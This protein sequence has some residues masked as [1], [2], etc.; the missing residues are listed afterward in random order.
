MQEQ[1][2]ALFQ[3]HLRGKLKP[4]GQGNFSTTCP[5]H[6][7]GMEK[8]P[9]FS[10]HPEKGTFHCFTCHT[11]GTVKKLLFLLGL[12]RAQIDAET[13]AVAPFLKRTQENARIQ[14]QHYFENKDPFSANPELPEVVLALYDFTPQKLIDDGFDPTILREMQIG[15]DRTNQRITYP[16]RDVHG[17]LAG[18]AGG[19]VQRGVI[20]KY[21]VYQG[22]Y[23]VNGKKVAGDFGES[24]DEEF[25]GYRF[26]NHQHIWNLDSVY[27]DVIASTDRSITVYLA[28]G[29]KACIWLRMAGLRYVVALMGSYISENQQ[30]LLH[31][32]GCSV[33]LFLDNDDAGRRGTLNVGDLLYKPLRGQVNVVPYPMHDVVASMQNPEGNTQP[34]DY[35]LDAVRLLVSNTMTFTQYFNM[36][37]RQFPWQ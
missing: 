35:E 28:E 22:G 4:A 7:G 6:K 11:A 34:D 13:R 26:E 14:R 33:T 37:R 5:F 16:I 12:S 1:V 15:F 19:A 29:Y 30:R 32:L 8:T 24:F 18:V 31:R 17:N 10:V 9:S 21:K 2:L 25:P 23:S 36:M 3:R 27:P 20:P